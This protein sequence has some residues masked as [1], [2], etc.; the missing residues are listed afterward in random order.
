MGYVE[1]D[2]RR[3]A[4]EPFEEGHIDAAEHDKRIGKYTLELQNLNSRKESNTEAI[5]SKKHFEE[6]AAEYHDLALILAH[7]DGVT[8]NVQQ[9]LEIGQKVEVKMPE[10]K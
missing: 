9:P 10:H 4:N 2:I 5:K 8:I 6:H 3:Y 7:M 1:H